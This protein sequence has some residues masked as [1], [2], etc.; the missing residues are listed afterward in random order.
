TA[1]PKN[2]DRAIEAQRALLAERPSDTRLEND[3]GSLL[4]LADDLAGA[5]QA[6]RRSLGIDE[7]NASA[8][9]N[10]AL[11]L[12]KQGER[13]AALKE[14][15][16]TIELQPRHAW[17]HYQ[18][19][20]IYHAQ[21]RESA[22]R[23]AYAKA[24]ALDPSLGNPEVNPH[25]IDNDL[26]TSAMLYSYRHYREELQPE[27]EFEEPARIAGVLI[28]RPGSETE[29]VAAVTEESPAASESVTRGVREAPSAVAP[30]PSYDGG[31]AASSED[32]GSSDGSDATES[33]VL[34]SKDLDPGSASGQIVGGGVPTRVGVGG[35]KANGPS[36]SVSRGRTRDTPQP[37][38]PTLR[39]PPFSSGG[40]IPPQDQSPST[41]LPTSDSTGMIETRLVEIDELS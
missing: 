32:A 29:A 31:D 8:H 28:D 17:A 14:F 2:L 13:R 6:Y 21:G 36:T 25:L 15:Q 40:A 30:E 23:K 27:K 22:A 10:L 4:V 24:L 19:G 12:Q 16:R 5:E 18:E 11:L 39:P 9:Y 20:T 33:R 26:A 41:F 34:T 37:V 7:E 35:V 38:R 1:A 3:L